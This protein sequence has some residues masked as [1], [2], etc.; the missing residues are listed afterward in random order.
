[1]NLFFLRPAS[2]RL[3]VQSEEHPVVHVEPLHNTSEGSE[4]LDDAIRDE[5]LPPTYTEESVA[6]GSPRNLL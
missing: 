3:R 6:A 5:D 1:M 4:F 2:K